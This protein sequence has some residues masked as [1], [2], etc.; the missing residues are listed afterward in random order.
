MAER[1]LNI[2]VTDIIRPG[3]EAVVEQILKEKLIPAL[4]KQLPNFKW[5]IYR[6][7]VGDNLGKMMLIAEVTPEQLVNY[8]QWIVTALEREHGKAEAS[9]YLLEWYESLHSSEYTAIVEDPEWS[10]Y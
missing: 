6:P 2:M 9:R 4:R 10:S 1:K 5:K 7:I 3:K 8:D